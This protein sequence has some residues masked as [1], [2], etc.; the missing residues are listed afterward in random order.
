MYVFHEV[1]HHELDELEVLADELDTLNLPADRERLEQIITKSRASFGGEYEN[2]KEREYVFVL[3]DLDEDMLVGAS[4]VIAQHGTYERPAVY[5][6]VREEQKY[7]D[8][9]DSF[10]NHEVLQLEF[11]YHGPTEVG[12]L[13]LHPDYRGHRFK[14]GKLLSY[15]RFLYIGMH[16]EWFRDRIVAD[17]LPPLREDGGSDLWSV[18]GENFTGLHY[19][20]ADRLSRESVEF[21]RDL[22]PTTP[23][24]TSL[25]PAA[26]REKIG[27]VGD[28]TKPAAKMLRNI[29]F[30]YDERI[31][32]FDGGPTLAV[33]TDFCKPVQ[34][35][36]S[37]EFAGELE[38]GEEV[39]GWA[40][41]GFEYE[42]H[43]VRFRG[44]F[45][46]YRHTPSGVF[47]RSSALGEIRVSKGDTLG[48]LPLSG[49]GVEDLYEPRTTE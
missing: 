6:N 44:A 31:D 11:D 42:E 23:I 1:R 24:Y 25:L 40:L 47:L 37:V 45:G 12:G 5:F 22:F 28:K 48:F 19:R 43:T 20:E 2:L 36:R 13:I 49:P 35:T 21:V 8:T 46:R 7:S 27:V 3:R 4:M 32:P 16:P 41:I 14:L 9:L 30:S 17:M 33:Q 34:R 10:F 29:G 15:I 39:D 38:E 26:A 18:I